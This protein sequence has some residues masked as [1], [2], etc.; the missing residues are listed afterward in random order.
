MNNSVCFNY[1]VKCKHCYL[2]TAP[3]H[4]YLQDFLLP[5]HISAIRKLPSQT[6]ESPQSLAKQPAESL[7]PLL[8]PA[9]AATKDT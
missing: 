3:E 5:G 9:I 7:C 4:R 2:C 6:K 8:M 1:H